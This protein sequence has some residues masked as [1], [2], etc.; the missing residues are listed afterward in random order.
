MSVHAES[1]DLRQLVAA[2]QEQTQAIN[3]LAASNRELVAVIADL[4]AEE[5]EQDSDAEPSTYMDGSP[6]R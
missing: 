4:L 2:M 5:G 1:S 6:R 3:A